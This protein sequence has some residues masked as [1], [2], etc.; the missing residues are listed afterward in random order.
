MDYVSG[1][2][3][4]GRRRSLW[5]ALVCL[6][7]CTLAAGASAATH[8]CTTLSA[9]KCI[10]RLPTGVAMG[11]VEVGP[12]TG[13]PVILIH[14][15][16][17]SLRTWDP[18]MSAL[19]RLDP[20]L[21]V[22][23]IDLR[24][25]GASSMPNSA[26]CAR[27]PEKCFRMT[28]F[29]RDVL[30]FMSAKNVERATLAGHSLGSMVVQELALTHPQ[31]VTRAILVGTTLKLGDPTAF[32]GFVHD[33]IEEQWCKKLIA[34]GKRF[35]EDFYEVSPFE[36][37]PASME[38]IA[39]NLTRDP[40]LSVAIHDPWPPETAR[41]KIGTWIGGIR[42]LAT[43]DNSKRIRSLA[44]PTLVIWGSQ[45]SFMLAEPDQKL[46]KQVLADA[47]RARSSINYWKQYGVRPLPSSGEQ[48]TDIGHNAHWAAPETM[49]ADIDAF[50][51]TGAPT[52]DLPHSAEAPDISRIMVERGKASVDVLGR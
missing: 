44:V 19:H 1:P 9:G 25:H 39:K 32:A 27:A 21:R 50:I 11:Y 34:L 22:F 17:D 49:A 18:A 6:S 5:I 43:F 3:G 41:V 36:A 38:F 51:R 47:A 37:D 29:A 33:H 2:T 42:V 20:K 7:V 52:A 35:P 24:S 23:A 12:V 8:S 26:T 40:T 4:A 10:Q 30:S 31:R 13:D 14:G 46:V 16:T 48:E 15:F 28:D 45:D